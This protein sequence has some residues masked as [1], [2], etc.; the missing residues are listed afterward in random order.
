MDLN[1]PT[2]VALLA[3][4]ALEN[5]GVSYALYGGLLTAVYGDPRETRDA[6]V[7]VID[8]TATQARDALAAA[9][10]RTLITF[11]DVRF[12]GLTVS[13][14]TLLGGAS[15]TGLNTVDLVRPRSARFA[16]GAV[17][18]AVVSTLREHRIRILA[19]EDYVAFKVLSTRDRD[20]EDARAA[21][22]RSRAA[23]EVA[24]L[25]RELAQLANEL[26]DVDVSGRWAAVRSAAGDQPG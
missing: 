8:V 2:T 9:G 12:G 20:L 15:D 24:L 16:A 5:A 23:L 7:A 18:R 3:A 25:E 14:L 11:E 26:P 21:L 22:H 6:D 19:L 1:D 4:D 10:A 13:R 17:A